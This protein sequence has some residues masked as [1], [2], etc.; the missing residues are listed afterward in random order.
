MSHII[1]LIFFSE[2]YFDFLPE[3]VCSTINENTGEIWTECK[4]VTQNMKVAKDVYKSA[5]SQ[6]NSLKC[7]VA[8]KKSE[9]LK[10]HYCTNPFSTKNNLR[11]HLMQ[12]RWWV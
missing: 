11:R 7:E 6:I 3:S 4:Q 8:E 10:C 1:W 9:E 5:R 2:L 12:K